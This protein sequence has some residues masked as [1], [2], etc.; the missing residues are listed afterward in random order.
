MAESVIEGD[1][2]KNQQT[3]AQPANKV[4]VVEVSFKS[5]LEGTPPDVT[6]TINDF[7]TSSGAT[8]A[9]PELLLRCEFEECNGPRVFRCTDSMYFS[10]E[11]NNVFLKYVCRNCGRRLYRFALLYKIGTLPSGSVM[12]YGQVPAFGSH[13]PARLLRLVQSDHELFL[14]G[15]RAENRGLGIGAFAYYRRVVEN[16]RNRIIAQIAK[17]AKVLGSTPEMDALFNDAQ[18][19]YQFSKSIEMVEHLIPQALMINGENPL[20]LLHSALS[21]GLHDPDMTDKHCLE[22]AQSI[23]TILTELA[24]R[25]AVAMKEDKEIATALKVL[26]AIPRTAKATA[27]AAVND[28]TAEPQPTSDAN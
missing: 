10:T 9:L 16:Q 19:Q 23:R 22:L 11:W 13:T 1:A 3:E 18:R 14:Q 6:V 17:V 21:K 4:E 25:A 24:D 28:A 12:K 2:G 7:K 26:K 8:L 20:I 5:F 15:R 27:E